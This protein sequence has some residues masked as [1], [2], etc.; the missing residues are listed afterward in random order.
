[1]IFLDN[2]DKSMKSWED[3]TKELM[4]Y[5][6]NITYTDNAYNLTLSN[7]KRINIL[8]SKGRTDAELVVTVTLLLTY[9]NIDITPYLVGISNKKLIESINEKYRAQQK[10]R[11][12]KEAEHY[13]FN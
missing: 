1:M 4:N 2:E 10:T 6:G 9:K 12:K 5:E 11:L 8:S 13:L 7:G 3:V